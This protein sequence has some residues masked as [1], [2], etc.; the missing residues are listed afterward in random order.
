MTTTTS[1][2]AFATDPATGLGTRHTLF[3]DLA[4]A[5]SPA[6]DPTVLA[7]FYLRGF[8]DYQRVY[9]TIAT[10]NL[11]MHMS[12]AFRCAIGESGRCYRPREDEFVALVD[13]TQVTAH[14]ILDATE[15]TLRDAGAD[16]LVT[17]S[18]G[19]SALPGE[20]DEAIAALALADLRLQGITG[21][22][23]RDRRRSPRGRDDS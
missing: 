22:G 10:E 18:F 2:P 8:K 12:A 9:G 16:F 21:R 23:P 3:T 1:A 5:V 4:R 11:L 19:T 13:G 20:A 6:A 14:P 17:T 15:T 7:I